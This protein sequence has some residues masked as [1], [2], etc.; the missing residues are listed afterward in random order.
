MVAMAGFWA[1]R[2][3]GANARTLA[4]CAVTGA[5]A[6]VLLVGHRLGLGAAVAGLLVWAP[7][8]PG[9]VRRRAWSDLAT[10]GLAVALVAVLAVRDAG[11][12]AALCVVA[13][14]GVGAVAATS[15]RSTP[16]VLVS[17]G[18]WAA[19]L[20]RALPWVGRGV[21][22]LA[23]SRRA[24]VVVVV[25]TAAITGGLLLVFGLL[26]ASA[27]RIFASYVP[28][29]HL[30][31]L[32][33]QVVVGVL[34]AVVAA[35][36]VH[37]AVAPPAWSTLRARPGRPARIGEWLLPVVALDAMVLAFVLVQ[38]GALVGG[39]RYVRATAGLS[40]AD[41]ARQGFAQLVVAT[42][43]TLVVVAVAARR[44]PRGSQRHRLLTRLALGA[45][46]LGTLGVVAA[47]LRR[48]ALYVD[49]FGLTRL[50]VL[51]V[52]VELVLGVVLVLVV[53][54]GVRWRAGWL[55]RT[56]VQV[57]AVAVLGLA[58]V[59][60]DA[61]IVRYNTSADSAQALDIGYLRGLSADAVPAMDALAE[62]LRSCLLAGVEV[63]ADDGVGGWNLGRQRAADLI[64]AAG[65]VLGG[66]VRTCF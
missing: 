54:A 61:Q 19:G 6:A 7:A 63:D 32:P 24:Q 20:V 11:W 58:L 15:A 26:F 44:A 17:L 65:P 35:A 60:P 49:A 55:P 59:N 41:Y 23:G 33:A 25:R 36:I 29:V 66:T 40:Y 12:V 8:V 18:T 39:N 30:D 52:V 56:V 43:L 57:V 13:S 37:L 14:G 31:L 53:V 62:P 10:A 38:V 28:A 45:L 22:T 1:A 27:D 50:R 64:A 4:L 2:H 5:V 47:A 48:M 21:G 46:C 51:A 42:A 16:A 3:P 34:V 9:L